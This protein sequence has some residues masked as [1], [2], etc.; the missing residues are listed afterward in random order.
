MGLNNDCLL[1]ICQYLKKEDLVSLSK[2]V[3]RRLEWNEHLSADEKSMGNQREF[4]MAFREDI[5]SL[6]IKSTPGK[7]MFE[8][9]LHGF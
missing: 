6:T 2:I 9:M 5:K 4:V 3:F 1:E 7:S 8:S